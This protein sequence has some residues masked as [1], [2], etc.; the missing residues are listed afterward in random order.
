MSRT[1]VPNINAADPREHTALRRMTGF[2][3]QTDGRTDGRT[4]FWESNFFVILSRL[5]K[6]KIQSDFWFKTH[7]QTD[8]QTEK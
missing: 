7:R 4:D 2:G 3:R 1:N 5:V 6:T 8:R